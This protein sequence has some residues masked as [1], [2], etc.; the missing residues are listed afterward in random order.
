MEGESHEQ[1]PIGV[2]INET[3]ECLSDSSEDKPE[4]KN[5]LTIDDEI[6]NNT[7]D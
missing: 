4:S 2:I 6:E 7:I 5:D 3:S 1:V